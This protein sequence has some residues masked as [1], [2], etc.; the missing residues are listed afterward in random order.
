MKARLYLLFLLLFSLTWSF[1]DAQVRRVIQNPPAKTTEKPVKEEFDENEEESTGLDDE[2]DEEDPDSVTV[3]PDDFTSSLDFLLENWA[4]DKNVT[5]NCKSEANPSTEEY[6]YRERLKKLPHLIEMPYNS[7]VKSFIEIYT[8][9][10]RKQVEYLLGLSEYYFPIFEEALE[11]KRLPL[12][13]KY[14][15]VIESALNPKAVSRAGATGMWQ[16]MIGTGKMYGLEVNTL[17]DERMDPVKSSKVAAEYLKE[18]YSIFSDWHLAIAAYNCGPGN[19][20]KAIRRA[21]GKR[22]FWTIYPYLPSE[23]RSYLPIF[24]AANYVINYADEHNICA[25]KIRIPALTDTIMLNRRVHMEQISA[26]LSIPLDE[27][28]LLNPQYRRDI[29]PGDIKP[30]PVCLPHN[31]ANMFIDRR[32]DIY[33][34]KAS[35]LVDNRR[36]EVEIPKP[37]YTPKKSVAKSKFTYV[38]VR[39]GQNLGSIAQRNHTTVAKIKKANGLKNTKIRTGQRLKIPR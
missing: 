29:I 3:I 2:N 9:Q 12:E 13:L 31:F 22:D 23:T 14:L 33:A 18:L 17:V 34:Y 26:V 10:R 30:Y 7:S 24:I 39:K 37:V 8:Q 11:A 16:F 6:L 36:D 21:G 35:T 20:N 15:P 28:R 19:V 32:D 4:V 1:S 5:T 27:L 25:A 38:T